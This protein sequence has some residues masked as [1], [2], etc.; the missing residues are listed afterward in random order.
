MKTGWLKDTDGHWYYMNSDG[1]MVTGR[2]TIGGV[3]YYF[4][5]Y[6]ALVE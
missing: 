3:S 5:K 4:N 2:K 6:G 1:A